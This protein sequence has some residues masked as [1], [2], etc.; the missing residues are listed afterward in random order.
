MEEVVVWLKGLELGELAPV[1]EDA[2][3]KS[4]EDILPLTTDDMK[5]LNIPFFSR[6][7]LTRAIEAYK[8]FLSFLIVS[9][10][11]LSF[12]IICLVLA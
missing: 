7:R 10:L 2:Q 4:I 12:L 9:H 6:K 8:V 3:C 1:L 11:M 5:E